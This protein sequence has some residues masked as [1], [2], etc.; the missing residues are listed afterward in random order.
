MVNMRGALLLM[1]LWAHYL[2]AQVSPEWKS[3][4]DFTERYNKPYQND[5]DVKNTRFLAFKV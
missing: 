2:H 5:S 1:V 3:F 4:E